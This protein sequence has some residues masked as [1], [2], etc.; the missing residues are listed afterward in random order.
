MSHLR[1]AAATAALLASFAAGLPMTTAAASAAPLQNRTERVN[2]TADGTQADA[3]PVEAKISADGRFATFITAA[4][5]LVPGVPV[6]E[7]Q[8]YVKDLRTGALELISAAPDGRPADGTSLSVSISANGRYIAFSSLATN[9]VPGHEPGDET[10]DI[11]VRDRETGRTELLI[12]KDKPD[13]AGDSQRP[14]ISADGRYVAFSSYRD[15][16]VPGDTNRGE[17]VFV[18]DR[19]EHTTTRVNATHD[20]RQQPYGYAGFPVISSDGSRVAFLSNVPLIPEPGANADDPAPGKEPFL[21]RFYVHD[22][23]TGK[24]E[25]VARRRNGEPAK[26]EGIG[27]LSPDGRYAIFSSGS[28]DIVAGDTN[29]QEDVFATDLSTGLTRR[30][31]LASDGSQP[32][33]RSGNAVMSADNRYVYFD[34]MAS[35]LVPG[36]TNH[37]NDV[38]VR[39]LLTGKVERVSVAADGSQPT[40]SSFDV[41]V[42]LTGRTALFTSYADDLVAGDTN[43]QADVFVRHLP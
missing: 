26:I 39:D 27:R 34:S 2:V 11:Y 32:N 36:D 43:Q 42:D 38:F 29:G 41:S 19:R 12:Q 40:R 31:S 9:L 30:L 1:R 14:T 25:A 24:T 21:R 17:D 7:R 35:N 28:P 16:L 22:L 3:E 4:T 15:D 8:V 13:T 6:N 10:L 5:A 33:G 20:G 37:V 23:R 18:H